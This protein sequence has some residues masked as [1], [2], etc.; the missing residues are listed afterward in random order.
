MHNLYANQPEFMLPVAFALAAG[1]CKTW[2]KCFAINLHATRL[3]TCHCSAT[4]AACTERVVA[5]II[6][7]AIGSALRRV[8]WA[9]LPH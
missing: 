3:L 4:Y 2:V 8:C 5:L 1:L 6:F 9:C 7:L